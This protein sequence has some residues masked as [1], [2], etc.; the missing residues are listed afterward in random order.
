MT[1]AVLRPIY[2]RTDQRVP[3]SEQY[4]WSVEWECIGT[5]ESMK[6]AKHKFGGSPVLEECH[7]H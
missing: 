3:K 4:Y 1:Y 7:V 6:E 2:T 5:A